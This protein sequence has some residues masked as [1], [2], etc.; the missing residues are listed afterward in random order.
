MLD[1]PFSLY[2]FRFFSPVD[3]VFKKSGKKNT[4]SAS[5]HNF[6]A[7][8]TLCEKAPDFKSWG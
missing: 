8:T 7:F 6:N 3:G 1:A 2:S 5:V 4:P